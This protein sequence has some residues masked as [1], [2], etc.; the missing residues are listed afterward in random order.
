M[1]G[2]SRVALRGL[3]ESWIKALDHRSALLWLLHTPSPSADDDANTQEFVS[4]GLRYSKTPAIKTKGRQR[5]LNK[6]HR[7]CPSTAEYS[8]L[9]KPQVGGDQ[10]LTYHL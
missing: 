1:R 9:R 4:Y 6:G 10:W 3:I 5:A 7:N 2:N 8:W